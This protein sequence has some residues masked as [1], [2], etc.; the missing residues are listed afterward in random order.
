MLLQTRQQRL[1][2][3]QKFNFKIEL[4]MCIESSAIY[5]MQSI[6]AKRVSLISLSKEEKFFLISNNLQE[7]IDAHEAY[8]S[9]MMQLKDIEDSCRK[10]YG[11]DVVNK[12]IRGMPLS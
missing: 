2:N 8:I 7:K 1:Q 3:K 5:I 12:L 4:N 10:K 9:A 11:N 6:D